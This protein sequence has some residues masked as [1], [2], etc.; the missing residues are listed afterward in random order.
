V[1]LFGHSAG[2]TSLHYHMLSENSRNLFHRG[3]ATGSNALQ[4]IV[5]TPRLN[6]AERLASLMGFN[7]SDEAAL[8]NFLENAEPADI[9]RQQNRLVPPVY[10]ITE[11][12]MIP[13][14]AVIEPYITDGVVLGD[15]LSTLLQNSW[16]NNITFII[17]AVSMENLPM[18]SFIRSGPEEFAV[19]TNFEIF[20]PKELG[21]ER[22]TDKSRKYAQMIRNVYYP[23]LA[24]TVTNVDGLLLVRF[25]VLKDK[26]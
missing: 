15:E 5:H 19:V 3:Y 12:Y 25:S 7:S 17:G 6:W 4:N 10:R 16:G 9:V 1:T 26:L 18:M 2:G 11:G 8:L 23:V 13:F 22:N 20:I 21:V 14:G 24:P